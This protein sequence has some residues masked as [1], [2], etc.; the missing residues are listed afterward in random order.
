LSVALILDLFSLVGLLGLSAFFSGSETAIFSLQEMELE[1]M[2]AQGGR[3]GLAAQLARNPYRTLVTLLLS[4]MVVNV[5]VVTVSTALLVEALGPAGLGVAIPVV[6]IMLLLCGEILPKT[7]GLRSRRRLAPLAAPG[8]DLLARALSPLRIVLESAAS[9]VSGPTRRLR[10][11]REELGTMLDLA[12]E[13]GL[14]TRFESRM[15]SRVLKLADTTVERILR[16]RVDVVGISR[17][18]SLEDAVKLF[19]ASGLSR[20]PVHEGS[21][22][23]VVGVLYLKDLIHVIDREESPSIESLAREPFFVPESKAADEL[24]AEFQRRR[25]H[26]AVVV[27]EHGGMEGIVTMEDLLEELIG[28]VHDES[29]VQAERLEILAPSIWRAD[30]GIELG[31]LGEALGRRVGEGLDAVTLAG[32]LEEELGKVPQAGDRVSRDGFEFR[33]LTAR[34]NRPLLVRVTGIVEEAR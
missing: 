25:V 23:H 8:V 30:A 22:D 29:D 5:A 32:L 17:E 21:L 3:S 4:N 15:L 33:V 7:L 18:A 6:T 12:Q 26:F 16:P 27:D 24:F 14:F 11:R 19:E 13:E 2:E 34:P 31:E 20:L 1:E 9:R 10:L 28:E